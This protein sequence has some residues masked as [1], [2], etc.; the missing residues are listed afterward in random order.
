[1]KKGKLLAAINMMSFAVLSAGAAGTFAWYTVSAANNRG[2]VPEEASLMTVPNNANGV[3]A[4][5]VTFGVTWTQD[6][7]YDANHVHFVNDDGIE[8]VWQNGTLVQANSAPGS[9]AYGKMTVQLG[10]VSQIRD[11]ATSTV[12]QYNDLS[13]DQKASIAGRYTMRLS[14]TSNRVHIYSS[15]PTTHF[16]TGDNTIT[17]SATMGKTSATP[18]ENAAVTFYYTVSGSNIDE[19]EELPDD[20]SID[21]SFTLSHQSYVP[22]VA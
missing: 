22:A 5:F 9:H 11:Q 21:F 18:I 1:M 12:T 10:N 7:T 16:T 13:A 19:D 17:V 20:E 8:Y 14:A 15:A 4:A 6:A 3:G 2:I